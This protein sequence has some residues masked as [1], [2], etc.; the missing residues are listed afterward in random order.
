MNSSFVFQSMSR[1]LLSFLFLLPLCAAA[2]SQ[3]APSMG[4]YVDQFEKSAGKGQYKI[5][6]E[7]LKRENLDLISVSVQ[8]N[9]KCG[10]SS[11]IYK[12]RLLEQIEAKG[13]LSGLGAAI[14]MVNIEHKNNG[15]IEVLPVIGSIKN[16]DANQ[17]VVKQSLSCVK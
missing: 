7:V 1:F 10:T 17:K 8:N 2:N 14:I 3:A 12:A 6:G 9:F 13:E 16:T 4:N 11:V 15:E 5:Y